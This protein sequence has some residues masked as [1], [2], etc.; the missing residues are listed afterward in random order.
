MGWCPEAA[1][2]RAYQRDLDVC[3]RY[4]SVQAEHQMLARLAIRHCGFF[5]WDQQESCT[6]LFEKIICIANPAV[7][8]AWTAAGLT[9]PGMGNTAASMLGP[10]VRWIM[11]EMREDWDQR[12]RNALK[13]SVELCLAM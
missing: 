7:V 13:K 4:Q 2:R 10:R 3:C 11:R 5:Q 6:C 12:C 1:A 8:V 9:D